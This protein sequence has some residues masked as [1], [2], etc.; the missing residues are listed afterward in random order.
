MA[1]SETRPM[2]SVLGVARFAIVFG[3]LAALA[4]LAFD[5]VSISVRLGARIALRSAAGIALPLVGA[6]YAL[7]AGRDSRE[8]IPRLSVA[9]RFAAALV[10]GA[11]T[12]AAIRFFLALL[13]FPVAELLLASCIAVL[14][15]AARCALDA[16]R[17]GSNRSLALFVGVASGMLLYVV[18]FGIPRVVPG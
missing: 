10:A 7:S 14:A 3:T 15:S 8:E 12:V 16:S 13:P 6:G 9:V 17:P 5:L 18:A 2:A 1:E 11:L 4:Y